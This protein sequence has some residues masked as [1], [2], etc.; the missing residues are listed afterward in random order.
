MKPMPQP[1][2]RKLSIL[3]LLLLTVSEIIQA[4]APTP[5][6]IYYNL[7]GTGTTVTNNADPVTRVNASGTLKGALAQ[8]G[9]PTYPSG[10][11]GTGNS[12][13]I[14]HLDT[15]WRTNLSGSW[16]ISFALRDIP[17]SS[18]TPFILFGDSTASNF[19][20]YANGSGGA[21]TLTMRATGMV[22]VVVPGGTIAGETTVVHFVYDA[23]NS[24]IRAYVN[25]VLVS[26]VDQIFGAIVLNGT[27]TFKVGGYS[28]TV[29]HTGLPNNGIAPGILD[30]FRLY[31]QALDGATIAAS[32]KDG[33]LVTKP[34][35]QITTTG[36]VLDIAD[37]SGN[38]DTLAVTQPSA[39][40][41][42]FATTGRTFKIDAG[43][44]LNDNSG[45]IPL[46]GITQVSINA[47]LGDDVIT[48]GHSDGSPQPLGQ[49]RP[50]R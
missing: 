44:L 46:A 8:G 39:G 15:G 11:I 36:G 42:Q 10:L 13:I 6:L 5:E 29:A 14:D 27:G 50:W 40:T 47:D 33:V 37:L 49:W 12:G 26:T 43:P 16:T 4:A 1:R 31:S 30:E 48:G 22:D 19:R 24:V 21:N 28:T 38:G 45:A 20:C 34:D 9:T 32:W 25:G 18:T 35:Y 17:S 23:P 41:I 2:S 3:A 7:D